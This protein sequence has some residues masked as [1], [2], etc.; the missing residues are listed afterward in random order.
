MRVKITNWNPSVVKLFVTLLFLQFLAITCKLASLGL[1]S[2]WDREYIIYS[3]I[4][5]TL[6]AAFWLLSAIG[7]VKYRNRLTVGRR[8]IFV[9]ISVIFG[10][11]IF[12]V[13][14]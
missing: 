13:V 6:S 10:I 9:I 3:G 4:V 8:R 2:T 7:A 5:G 1:H 14:M 12:G 11:V